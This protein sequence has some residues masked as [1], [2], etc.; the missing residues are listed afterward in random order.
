VESVDD[1]KGASADLT[2][3]TCSEKEERLRVSL[4]YFF[5]SILFLQGKRSTSGFTISRQSTKFHAA[6]ERLIPTYGL[7][8]VNA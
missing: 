1:I 6:P 7:Q 4:L 5:M 3:L 2:V 8:C